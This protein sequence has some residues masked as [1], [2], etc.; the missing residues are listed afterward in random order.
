MVKVDMDSIAIS[1]IEEHKVAV[2]YKVIFD[3]V[4]LWLRTIITDGG[5]VTL[6]WN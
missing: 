2:E 4:A 5:D 1:Q 6:L 3:G